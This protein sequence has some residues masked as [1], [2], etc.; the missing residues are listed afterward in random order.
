LT[1]FWGIDDNSPAHYVLLDPDLS[2]CPPCYIVS[3]EK[4]CLR[5]DGVVFDLR[6]R[7]AGVRSKLDMYKG[8]PHWFHAFP[9]LQVAHTMMEKSVGGVRWLLGD[10][11]A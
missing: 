3:A 7:D 5:D 1:A 2:R 9:Q 6:L 4:D 11:E 8:L 10:E